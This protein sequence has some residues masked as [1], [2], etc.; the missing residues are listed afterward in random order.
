MS[1]TKGLNVP[2]VLFLVGLWT[3]APLGA[4]TLPEAGFIALEGI[5]HYFHSG[6][7]SNRI[8]L[9]SS[10]ARL[11]Y[12]YQPAD[13][14][15][16]SKPLFVF[17][18]GGPGS[19]TSS[20]LLTTNTASLTVWQ[21][22]TTGSSAV[23]ANPASWTRLGNI[24][25]VDA[26]T[27]GFSYSLMDDPSDEEARQAE[28]DAQNYNPFI[29]G[30]DF[31]RLLL[32]FLDAHPA[33]RANPVALV[34]ESYGGIRTGVILHLLLYSE[35]Y[36]D[37]SEVYQNPG[38]VE[39]IRRHYD[40]VF[41]EY[42]GGSL[43]PAVVARQF[44]R[45]ILIQTAVSLPYQ[46]KV[47]V[48]KL[49]APGSILDRLA[50]ETGLAYVRYR[51]QPGA[52]PNPT[53]SQIMNY[54]YSYLDR[55]GRDPYIC[56]KPTGFLQG[57]RDAAEAFLMRPDTLSLLIGREAT[58]IP[59]L[60]AA[61]RSQ[62]Y[63]TK[64]AGGSEADLDLSALIGPPPSEPELAKSFSTAGED[65]LAA[66]FGSLK[67]WDRYF[68]DTNYD[69]TNAFAWNR[70]TFEGYDV[71]HQ[72][73][74]LYGRLFLENA[75]WVETFA[76]D[77]A[78]DLVVFTPALAEALG[79]HSAILSRSEFDPSGPSGAARPGRIILTY[80]SGVVPGSA[81]TTRTIRFPGYSQSGHAVTQTE[82]E[83]ILDD[84]ADWLKDTE[85]RPPNVKARRIS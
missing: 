16:Q 21:D 25:Y 38:L 23:R 78:F 40:L 82:P 31:V 19:A 8:A 62:A 81:V 14:D 12:V 54:I 59:E 55:I 77:A 52:N 75:A 9:R 41:P 56:S 15:P 84:V 43:P 33:I 65:G 1:F 10:P 39:E 58:Q 53:P 37:G 5:D 45:Q 69:A 4:Q 27:T 46:R 35:R 42:A 66:V 76:T 22:G 71:A 20:G 74:D 24:L 70:A 48:E 2:I 80:R 36:A 17:F 26:R 6:S 34:P 50:A 67:P 61:A 28:F 11:W 85:S 44:G 51:D 32:R 49:E 83:E 72:T 7:W 18:N 68:M 73:S 29:D 3:A 63:K 64:Y 30:T 57:Q 13:D 60:Y 79:L 47:A